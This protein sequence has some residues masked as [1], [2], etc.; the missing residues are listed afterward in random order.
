M[1]RLT[2]AQREEIRRKYGL[3]PTPRQV[4]QLANDFGL[5]DDDMRSIF[6]ISTPVPEYDNVSA[7]D[8]EPGRGE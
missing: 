4:R 2:I 8:P 7:L 3:N 5:D 6:Y 1:P